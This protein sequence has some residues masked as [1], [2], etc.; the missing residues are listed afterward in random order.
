MSAAHTDLAA[1]PERPG[2]APAEACTDLG[3]EEGEPVT[4]IEALKVWLVMT[5]PSIGMAALLAFLLWAFKP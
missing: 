4:G 5:V 1:A 3:F 2:P